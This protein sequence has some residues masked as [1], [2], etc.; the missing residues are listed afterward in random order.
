MW[1]TPTRSTSTKFANLILFFQAGRF[2]LRNTSTALSI[3]PQGVEK[4]AL[5]P[6]IVQYPKR[7]QDKTKAY[8]HTVTQ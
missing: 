6:Y 3:L 1:F 7:I 4:S 5:F 8:T 2:K